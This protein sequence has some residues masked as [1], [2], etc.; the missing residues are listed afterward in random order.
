MPKL[1]SAWAGLVRDRSGVVHGLVDV[2]RV[3]PGLDPAVH[4]RLQGADDHCSADRHQDAE[5]HPAGPLGGDV[6]HHHEDAEEDQRGAEVALEDQH[7][8]A[9]HPDRQHRAGVAPARQAQAPDLAADQ[10]QRVP[11]DRQ[12]AGEE[13]DDGELDELVRL[14]RDPGQPDPALGAEGVAGEEGG[15]GQQ[16]QRADHQDVDVALEEPVVLDQ[17]DQRDRREDRDVE[18][19]HLGGRRGQLLVVTLGGVHDGVRLVEPVE[20]HH[21]EAAEQHR[22]RQDQ[23]VRVAREAPY[24]EVHDEREQREADA[25]DQQALG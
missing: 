7:Q 6:E 21:A 8:Q 22:A 12:V 24:R 11:A 23:R 14:Q 9:D 18:P 19:H 17:H 2:Q 3:Q 13:D 16:H 20:Q 4:V 15:R 25:V 1:N 10:R 5:D